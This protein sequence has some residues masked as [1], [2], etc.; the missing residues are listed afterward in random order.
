MTLGFFPQLILLTGS[1]SILVESL[2]LVRSFC[3]LAALQTCI[4]LSHPRV[5]L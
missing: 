5:A 3:V 4:C 2:L 1:K